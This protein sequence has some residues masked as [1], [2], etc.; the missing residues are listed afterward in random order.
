MKKSTIN[1]FEVLLGLLGE[2]AKEISRLNRS[3]CAERI[4]AC[5]AIDSSSALRKQLEEA[6]LTIDE[7]DALIHSLCSGNKPPPPTMPFPTLP[8]GTVFLDD[9][10]RPSITVGYGHESA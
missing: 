8:K 9:T 4:A 3:V 10:G 6:R 1:A 7:K 5:Q 2:Q